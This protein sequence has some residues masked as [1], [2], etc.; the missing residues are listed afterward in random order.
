MITEIKVCIKTRQIKRKEALTRTVSGKI[1]VEKRDIR[2]KDGER[3]RGL[4]PTVCKKQEFV[5]GEALHAGRVTPRRRALMRQ[6]A[7]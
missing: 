1:R 4:Q 7:A 3:D 6:R 5:R 2:R